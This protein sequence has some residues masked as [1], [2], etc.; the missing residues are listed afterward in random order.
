MAESFRI[1]G[2]ERISA[3]LLEDISIE[4]VL[5]QM[6]DTCSFCIKNVK[7]TEGDEVIVEVNGKRL[8][9]G[10]VDTVKLSRRVGALRIWQVEC[11]DYTYQLDRRLVVETYENRTADWIVRD[12]CLKYAPDFAA[13]HVQTGAPNVAFII[14][15][16]QQPSECFKKLAEYCGW[17]W[18]VDY[19]RDVWFFDPADTT[20]S[21]PVPIDQTF[22]LRN[23]KHDIQIQGLR[24]RVYVRGGVMLSDPFYYETKADGLARIWML[25]HKPHELS[26]QIA[27]V[28]VSV[29]IENV[30]DE[31]E[32][33]YLLNYQEKYVK[34]SPQ[35]ATTPGGSTLSFTYRYDID[36]ITM[37]DD[38]RSQQAVAAVQG[39]DGVYEHVIVDPKLTSIEAAE[40]AGQA[41]L[42]S[43]A[44]PRVKGSFD[45]ETGEWTPGQL[46]AVDLPDI[47]V[48]GTYL[49][50]S[51]TLSP[52]TPDQWTYH[53]EYGGR[54]LG[55]PDVLQALVSS[56][57][58]AGLNETA[59]LNK[60]IYGTEGLQVGDSLVTKAAQLPFVVE[61]S[62]EF[63]A[64]PLNPVQTLFAEAGF[65]S[66]WTVDSNTWPQVEMATSL[67]GIAFSPWRS[68]PLHQT[69]DLQNPGYVRF[70]A[71]SGRVQGRVWKRPFDETMTI[72][73]G[74]AI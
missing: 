60:F 19:F 47:G 39:G 49:V 20:R 59:R 18:Y 11:Q 52:L 1:A 70:R 2:I 25:P 50:Q 4:Q 48:S 17:D 58:N 41:D 38:I 69:I 42:R 3:I 64:T 14:F 23:I 46:I 63:E 57:K 12:I 30:H 35:T 43:H 32:Y 29:G 15:D 40:A 55:I 31:A 7:P 36:V 10:I 51:V 22:P 71:L 6:V 9:A 56:Q 54:L 37:I 33:A 62:L 53:V 21:S 65:L 16:Y 73:N 45:T 67:D 5:T 61:Q 28:P 74:V 26:F 66:L 44:N 68:V 13:N 72:C 8:F 24:N 27:G 34:A